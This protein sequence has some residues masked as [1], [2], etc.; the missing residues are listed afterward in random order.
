M[1][2]IFIPHFFC[3]P[4][5]NYNLLNKKSWNKAILFIEIFFATD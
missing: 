2:V 1:L 3:V 5:K 4:F